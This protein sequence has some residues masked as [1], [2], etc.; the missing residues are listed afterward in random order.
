MQIS[1]VPHQTLL[2]SRQSA[3]SLWVWFFAHSY[4][5]AALQAISERADA[6]IQCWRSSNNLVLEQSGATPDFLAHMLLAH[7]CA[8]HARWA[9]NAQ[10]PPPSGLVAPQGAL[11]LG[12]DKVGALTAAPNAL[13][14]A[15]NATV[16]SGFGLLPWYLRQ[17][18][19][20]GTAAPAPAAGA[21]M[22]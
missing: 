8:L 2:L 10:T 11:A 16:G 15:P 1:L 3:G 5:C 17:P 4:V 13:A 9:W 19:A 7:P 18:P 22:G 20:N 21:A 14:A 6:A 12:W